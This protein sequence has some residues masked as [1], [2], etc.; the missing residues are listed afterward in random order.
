[1][2]QVVFYAL[3]PVVAPKE[4]LGEYMGINNIFLCIP[5]I[6]SNLIGG[7]LITNGHGSLIF[8][9]SIAALVIACII[10]ASGKLQSANPDMKI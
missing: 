1:M 6:I 4:K 2:L 8:P 5:Q 3:I 10:I 9:I 7:Y